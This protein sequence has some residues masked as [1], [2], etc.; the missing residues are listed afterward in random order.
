M[1][2]ENKYLNQPLEFWANVR[3]ISQKVG[4]TDRKT[5]KIKVNNLLVN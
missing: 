4:Y 5:S 2:A 3:L 1:K